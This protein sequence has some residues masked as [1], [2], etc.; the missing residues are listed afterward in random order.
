MFLGQS[1]FLPPMWKETQ[2]FQVRVFQQIAMKHWCG[3]RAFRKL[4]V[5]MYAG[6]S[7]ISL[8]ESSFK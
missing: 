6:I 8:L 1:L 5:S 7:T 2:E 4:F 3:I